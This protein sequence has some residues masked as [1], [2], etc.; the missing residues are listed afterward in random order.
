MLN[1][2]LKYKIKINQRKMKIYF[3]THHL[4]VISQISLKHS[5]YLI[6]KMN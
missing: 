5:V 6:I 4:K 1:K 2:N 3:N